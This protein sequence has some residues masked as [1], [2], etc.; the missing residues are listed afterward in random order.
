MSFITIEY[1]RNLLTKVFSFSFIILIG[2]VKYN[3]VYFKSEQVK[4]L[5]EQVLC[6][7]RGLT[8][9]KEIEIIQKYANKGRLYTIVSG[10]SLYFGMLLFIGMFFIPDI[11]DVMAPLNEPRPHQLPIV[12]ETFF[13]QEK[14]FLFIIL[15]FFVIAGVILTILFTVETLYMIC[16][17]HACG[18]LQLTS[19]R[20]LTAFDNR[21]QQM[22]MSKPKCIVCVKLTNAIRIH[23]RSLE[24]VDCLCSTFS[25][26]YFFLCIFG[27]TS[28]SINL[29]EVSKSAG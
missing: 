14:H 19:Y 15:N 28:L 11:L 22:N 25:I 2:T 29:F 12:I 18:L 20:I 5:F 8:D 3:V 23:R 17:Q 13:D 21:L 26:S 6:D 9:A 10:L 27:V 7:W 1:S 24:F 4:H 16:V